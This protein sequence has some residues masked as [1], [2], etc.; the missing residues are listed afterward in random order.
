M[1]INTGLRSNTKEFI[2]KANK[3]HNYKYD[4]NL[5]DYKNAK[6]KVKI[7]CNIHGI[8]NIEPNAHLNGNGCSK[9]GRLSRIEKSKY[10]TETFIEKSNIRHNNFYSY[11]KTKYT[12]STEEVNIECPI[13]GEFK[14]VAAEHL[15]GYG[16]KKCA[17]IYSNGYKLSSW[18]KY[19]N[20]YNKDVANLYYIK[21]FNN[22]E[23]FIKIGISTQGIDNRFKYLYLSNYKY[24]ILN[25]M[26]LSP[27]ECFI[28][29]K[30]IH[31]KFSKHKYTPNT[32]FRGYTE[33]FDVKILKDL[34]YE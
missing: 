2:E 21:I 11:L 22:F 28:K 33:C 31:K 4:Y 3:I 20:R 8:F 27:K 15:R 24:E 12:K 26:E 19:C 29:E 5:V 14:Q 13:H 9:C 17:E 30:E 23:E 10:T 18:L 34:L 1:Y 32:K 16:C 25:V 6:T 7:I